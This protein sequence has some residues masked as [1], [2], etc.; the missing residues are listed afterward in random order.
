MINATAIATIA[1]LYC[2]IAPRGVEMLDAA[3]ARYDREGG[4]ASVIAHR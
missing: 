4:R 3:L 1:M 2:S